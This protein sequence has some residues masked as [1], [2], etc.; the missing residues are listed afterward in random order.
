MRGGN[1]VIGGD[2]VFMPLTYV[3]GNQNIIQKQPSTTHREVTTKIRP[4]NLLTGGQVG[5]R[6][7]T[8]KHDVFQVYAFVSRG[9][10]LG[11]L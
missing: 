5:I 11:F 6:F 9:L 4:F 8:P 10:M 7:F 2:R 1:G 3:Q